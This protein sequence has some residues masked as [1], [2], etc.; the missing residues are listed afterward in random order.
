M[1]DYEAGRELDGLIAKHIMGWTEEELHLA[2]VPPD[3]ET[4]L[5][6]GWEE[7]TEETRDWRRAFNLEGKWSL[8]RPWR[9]LPRLAICRA[10]LLAM[11]EGM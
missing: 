7:Y 3:K 6:W 2:L 4:A 9:N 8:H 10:A 5:K 11:M 1:N